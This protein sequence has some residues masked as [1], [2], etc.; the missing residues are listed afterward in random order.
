MQLIDTKHK[1][2]DSLR[3]QIHTRH[4]QNVLVQNDTQRPDSLNKVI[5]INAKK[6]PPDFF[7]AR[8]NK[9]NFS[10]ASHKN[11]TRTSK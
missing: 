4:H 7:T 11:S 10:T 5:K 1:N 6:L 8:K 3:Q 2:R 9:I